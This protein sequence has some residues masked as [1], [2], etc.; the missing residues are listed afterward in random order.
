[1]TLKRA[2][3]VSNG[4]A[5]ERFQLCVCGRYVSVQEPAN[6]AQI[7]TLKKQVEANPDNAMM[8]MMQLIPIANKMLG[9]VMAKYGFT[10]EN[11]GVMK[12]LNVLQ[13]SNDEE[14]QK[15]AKELRALVVPASML[16]MVEAMFGGVNKGNRDL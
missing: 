16:P 14:I 2:V 11:G 15:K 9:G 4:F 13:S 1:L 6:K 12:F 5:F 10:E 7:D 8:A 3:P